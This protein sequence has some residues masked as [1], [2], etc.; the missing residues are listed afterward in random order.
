MLWVGGAA[1]VVASLETEDVVAV[2]AVVAVLETDILLSV[3]VSVSSI[4]AVMAVAVVEDFLLPKK[5]AGNEDLRSA[6]L[7]V[8]VV[9]EEV[10]RLS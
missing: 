7:D 6:C 3:S 8:I 4:G 9:E 2:V 10:V 1:I 5:A